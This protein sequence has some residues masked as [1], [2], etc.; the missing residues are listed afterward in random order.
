MKVAVIDLQYLPCLDYFVLIKQYDKI[1]IEIKE[2]FVKQTY[3]NR[4]YIRAANSIQRLSVPVMTGSQTV[5]MEEVRIDYSQKWLDMHW[6]TLESAYGKAP[7]FDFFAQKIEQTLKK[8]NPTLAELNFELLSVCLDFLQIDTPI[9][10]TT[11]YTKIYPSEIK[12][13]RS[14][15]HPKKDSLFNYPPYFQLFGDTFV[16][17]LSIIDALLC[18]GLNTIN[19]IEAASSKLVDK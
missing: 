4:C 11:E 6:R 1:F 17:N 9:V 3:R 10:K 19:I 16:G 18:E 14:D 13:L 12:D 8:E 2:H 7:F 5:A 15:V